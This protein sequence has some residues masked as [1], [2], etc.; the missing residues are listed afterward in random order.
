VGDKLIIVFAGV[1]ER[2]IAPDCKSGGLCLRGFE[3]LPQHRICNLLMFPAE[4]AQ[5]AEHVIGNDKVTGSSPVLG[6]NDLDRSIYGKKR[7]CAA[8]DISL[9][10]MSE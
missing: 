7:H 9:F 5:L 3:S 1:A 4:I 10:K 8:S 6:S 2:S